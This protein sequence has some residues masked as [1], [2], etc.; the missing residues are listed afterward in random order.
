MCNLML[1]SGCFRRLFVRG[2]DSE[3]VTNSILHGEAV[4][5]L[6]AVEFL[7]LSERGVDQH[8]QL[9]NIPD[10]LVH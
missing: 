9:S 7:R 8:L 6:S 3:M 1:R 5:D 4:K 10:S 2:N